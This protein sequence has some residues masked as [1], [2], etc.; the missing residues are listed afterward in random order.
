MDAVS[1]CVHVGFVETCVDR[2][3]GKMGP[4]VCTYHV[5]AAGPVGEAEVLV[6]A[7]LLVAV[8]HHGGACACVC[9]VVDVGGQSVVGPSVNLSNQ[10]RHMRAKQARDHE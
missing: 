9:C 7:Q 6:P 4:R 8:K 10:N 2:D 3:D 5:E 1:V